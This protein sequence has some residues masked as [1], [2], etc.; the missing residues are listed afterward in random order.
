MKI[1]SYQFGEITIDGKRYDFDLVLLPDGRIVPWQYKERHKAT[2]EDTLGFVEEI[3]PQIVIFGT[4]DS[5]LFEASAAE[6]AIQEK[7]IEVLTEPTGV[8]VEAYNDLSRRKKTLAFF[9]LTC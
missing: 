2:E 9:H 5:G 3:Q 1:E 7:G 8:A 6:R 4:G